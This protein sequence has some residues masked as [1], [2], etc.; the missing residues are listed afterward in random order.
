MTVVGA[1]FAAGVAGEAGIFIGAWRFLGPSGQEKLL[2]IKLCFGR[3]AHRYGF[4][5]L[6]RTLVKDL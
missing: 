1:A 6:G 5:K 4:R 2:Q 3:F